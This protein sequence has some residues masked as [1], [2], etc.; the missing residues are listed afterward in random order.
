MSVI[1]HRLSLF[2]GT[3]K[4]TGRVFE[5]KNSASGIA[6]SCAWMECDLFK[7]YE[8]PNY[9]LVM[10]KML[11]PEASDAMFTSFLNCFVKLS[12]IS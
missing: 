3:G 12:I 4:K 9:A 8:E 6:T 10:G 11:R 1:K 5:K 7:T 2:P